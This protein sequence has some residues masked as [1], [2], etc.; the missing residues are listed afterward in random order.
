MTVHLI[1]IH[2]CDLMSISTVYL[3]FI[4]FVHVFTLLAVLFVSFSESLS[5]SV[6]FMFH[7]IDAQC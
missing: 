7:F 2:V 1:K 5:V 4:C 3:P 6:L